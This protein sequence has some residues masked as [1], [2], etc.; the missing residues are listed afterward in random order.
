MHLDKSSLSIPIPLTVTLDP[1]RMDDL[2]SMFVCG[3][4]HSS[5]FTYNSS[6][7]IEND[8]AESATFDSSKHI[9]EIKIKNLLFSDG[10]TITAD[11]VMNSLKRPF[12]KQ[13]SISADMNYIEG[14]ELAIKG[15]DSLAITVRD[16][17]T[18]LI[19]LKYE[20]DFIFKHLALPD[21]AILKINKFN[22]ELPSAKITSGSYF[23][24]EF[25]SKRLVLEKSQN[26][27]NESG[28]KTVFLPKVEIKDLKSLA[29]SGEIDTTE[30]YQNL[31]FEEELMTNNWKKIVT[32]Q[33]YE[34]FLILNPSKLPRIF[35][36]NL[37][38]L[39]NSN[40]FQKFI[41]EN[42]F[43]PA[44]G[45]VPQSLPGSIYKPI[46]SDL[47]LIKSMPQ[48]FKL[49]YSKSNQ[50]HQVIAE[51]LSNLL[52][53]DGHEIDLE[54][55]ELDQFYAA[56]FAK[57][58]SAIIAGKGLDY[59]DAYANLSYY[60]TDIAS[61]FLFMENSDLD[62]EIKSLTRVVGSNRIDMYRDIQTKIL[63]HRTVFPLFFGTTFS[64]LWSP[65][66]K[67]V[68]SHPFGIQFLKL[69]DFEMN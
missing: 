6:G 16:T 34:N 37:F 43:I 41:T 12:S 21:L 30:F 49:T 17:K 1:H 46:K 2:Y 28:P 13:A 60:V 61:N 27:G 10:T 56:L 25:D 53:T 48:K 68:P 35:R 55:L 47:N 32:G 45:L 42:N 36:E 67:S 24:S 33:T 59:P 20:T 15:K 40:I 52:I 8:I 23:V 44:F 63:S 7:N 19:K 64:S 57:K 66:V 39:I 26:R 18:I 14:Y 9:L 31:S 11:H 38:N 22:D 62:A 29:L 65:K 50:S 54:P 58:S 3:Q 69:K 4:I 51:M 5:L